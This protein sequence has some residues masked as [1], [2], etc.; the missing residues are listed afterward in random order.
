MSKLH[1]AKK[2]AI[3]SLL[4]FMRRSKVNQFLVGYSAFFGLGLVVYLSITQ[5]IIPTY[6][7]VA[8]ARSFVD[9]YYARVADT[10]VGTEPQLTL[11][12]KL[13]Y[14]NVKIEAVRTFIYHTD[15]NNKET[16]GE[17]AFE[18]NVSQGE[19]DNNCINVRLKGQPMVAGT[20]S[21]STSV[22]FF[23]GGHRKTYSYNSNQYKMIAVETTDE[24]KIQQLQKQIDEL[25]AESDKPITGNAPR[26]D[27][28][29]EKPQSAAPS[30]SPPIADAPG[31]SSP[32]KDNTETP[33]PQ[34]NSLF[35]QVN[36]LLRSIGF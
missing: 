30:T 24:E 21:T 22:E 7:A 10:P 12:R 28:A 5:L 6:Y 11:C 1:E 20:Y 36:R 13:N 23:V 26:V 2:S 16:V 18:A 14:D 8:P 35:G 27:P 17:Y 19:S 34:D 9:Y 29:P 15:N 31:N 32:P 4:A 33:P 3:Q 25:R